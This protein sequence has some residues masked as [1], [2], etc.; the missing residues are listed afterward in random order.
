MAADGFSR[1]LTCVIKDQGTNSEK[2]HFSC[3]A[4]N[5]V[6]KNLQYC[7]RHILS[8]WKSLQIANVN[9]SRQLLKCL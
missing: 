8:S 2:E 7:I 9:Q 6:L 1:K 5:T 4:G 3:L